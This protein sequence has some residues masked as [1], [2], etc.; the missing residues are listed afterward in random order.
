MSGGKY[1]AELHKKQKWTWEW[2][3]CFNKHHSERF[4]TPLHVILQTK[5]II[6][7]TTSISVTFFLILQPPSFSPYQQDFA[8]QELPSTQKIQHVES[9]DAEEQGQPQRSY[10]QQEK[11]VHEKPRQQHT[12][13]KAGGEK[14]YEPCPRWKDLSLVSACGYVIIWESFLLKRWALDDSD[15]RVTPS[16]H[17]LRVSASSRTL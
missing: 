7:L 16:P 9:V 4:T 1:G 13:N 11:N 15:A 10:E 14:K 5:F 3:F 17:V 8:V 6:Y 12:L 2:L